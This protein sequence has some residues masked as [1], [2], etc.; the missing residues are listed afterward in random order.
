MIIKHIKRRNRGTPRSGS[1]GWQR[2]VRYVLREGVSG[3]AEREGVSAYGLLGCV[4]D[5]EGLQRREMIAVIEQNQSARSERYYHL[6]VSL[7]RGETLPNQSWEKIVGR[8][9]DRLGFGDHHAVWAIHTDT[10]HEHMH[11]VFSKIHPERFTLHEPFRAYRGFRE[12]VKECEAEFGLRPSPEPKR[13][14]ASGKEMEAHRGETSLLSWLTTELGQPLTAAIR[15]GQW[16]G[17]R[18]LL[19]SRGL[20]VR[21]RGRGYVVVEVTTKAMVKFSDISAALLVREEAKRLEGF[22]PQ[23]STEASSP[24][25]QTDGYRWLPTSPESQQLRSRYQQESQERSEARAQALAAI[26]RERTESLTR[27]RARYRHEAQSE[28]HT[29]PRPRRSPALLRYLGVKARLEHYYRGQRRQ[30]YQR[31]RSVSWKAFLSDRALYDPIALRVLKEG[32]A[33]RNGRASERGVVGRL[34]VRL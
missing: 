16:S 29:T 14:S 6:I 12:L 26:K 18:E 2:V 5:T 20:E 1:G 8:L 7:Q 31:T 33:R 17:V 11:V 27:E 3:K 25:Q 30:V 23:K 32:E 10:E 34:G 21:E 15:A 28:Q 4:S 19:H 22:T 13:Q 24:T 9:A